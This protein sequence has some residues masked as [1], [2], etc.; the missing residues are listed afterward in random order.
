MADEPLIEATL[1][2]S[3]GQKAILTAHLRELQ[4]WG[5]PV[6]GVLAD[7]LKMKLIE[8]PSPPELAEPETGWRGLCMNCGANWS[9]FETECLT[10]KSHTM[11]DATTGEVVHHG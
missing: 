4:R 7:L 1:E 3:D 9:P 10:C 6:H 2:I 11:L 5:K 8:M